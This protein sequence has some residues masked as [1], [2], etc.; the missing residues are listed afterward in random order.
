VAAACS[1]EQSALPFV[2]SNEQFSTHTDRT[3]HDGADENMDFPSIVLKTSDVSAAPE[4]QQNSP[5]LLDQQ[6]AGF[7]TT[8]N[9]L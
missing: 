7:Q 4:G 8:Y 6:H 9:E 2:S 3:C 5:M 1:I